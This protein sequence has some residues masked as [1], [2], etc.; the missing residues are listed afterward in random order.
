MLQI[1]VKAGLPIMLPSWVEHIWDTATT[2]D[3]VFHATDDHMVRAGGV[4]VAWK[5]GGRGEGRR[6]GEGMAWKEGRRK[7]KRGGPYVRM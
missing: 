6:E 5:G 1:A 2:T 4:R 7:G 3:Q